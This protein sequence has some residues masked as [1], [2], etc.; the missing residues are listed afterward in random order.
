MGEAQVRGVCAF[1]CPK[2][3]EYAIAVEKMLVRRPI[4]VVE[5]LEIACAGYGATI[6]TEV[7][8]YIPDTFECPLGYGCQMTVSTPQVRAAAVS[9]V[10]QSGSLANLLIDGHWTRVPRIS[11]GQRAIAQV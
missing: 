4:I 2:R 11:N 8:Q 7:Y 10:G 5:Q 3:A 1:A 9:G 6:Y